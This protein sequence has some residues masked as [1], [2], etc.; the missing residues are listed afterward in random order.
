MQV[1]KPLRETLE[2]MT[3][4]YHRGKVPV[5][6]GSPSRAVPEGK[7]INGEQMTEPT[8]VV[9]PAVNDRF[10]Q[11]LSGPEE[12]R[13]LT[14]TLSHELEHIRESELTSKADFCE[15]Y[16]RYPQFAGGVINI[17]ED[18]YIDFTRTQRFPGLRS[19]QAFVTNQLLADDQLWPPIDSIENSQK[20]M[21]EGFRQVAFAGHAKGIE[22]ADGWLREFLSRVRPQIKRVRRE[23]SQSRRKEIAHAVMKVAKEYLPKADIKMPETCSICKEQSPDIIAPLL[24]PVCEECA[25][26]GHGKHDG[27]EEDTQTKTEIES[28]KEAD[29]SEVVSPDSEGKPLDSRIDES[30]T[31]EGDLRQT[32]TLSDKSSPVSKKDESVGALSKKSDR[33]NDQERTEELTTMD[34]LAR[35]ADTASWWDVP[36]HVDHHTPNEQDVVRYERIRQEKQVDRGLEANLRHQREDTNKSGCSLSEDCAQYSANLRSEEEWYQLRDELRRT[37]RKLTTRDMPIPSKTG[38]DLNMDAVIQRK[39]GDKSQAKLYTR[40]QTVA[41]GNRVVAISADMSGSM[42]GRLVKLAI[43]AIAEATAMVSDTFLATCWRGTSRDSGGY[44][45]QRESTDF[46]LVCGADEPFQWKQLDAFECAGGTPTADGIDLTSQL[47]EDLHARE[48]LMIVI[49]DGKPNSQYSSQELT[50]SPVGDANQVVQNVQSKN[51]NVIGLYVGT[52]GRDTAMA[53][54]FGEDGFV[55]ASMN[56][57]SQ[58]L[59]QIYRR[60]LRV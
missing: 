8:V 50:A 4:V 13:C 7:S 33:K 19:T 35:D 25:P 36:D 22:T 18:Q 52:S 41:R 10:Q 38:T 40:K 39:A 17:L 55:S 57:L 58:E 44:L 30:V 12:L 54:I 60:Q 9:D 16:E 1:S 43:A 59:I 26:T 45:N 37:F 29:T 51:I 49:T 27:I 14:N 56:E 21:L 2:S 34:A 28:D 11:Q 24:G 48:R 6:F 5:K 32:N 42:D 20:A 31:Q 47:M 23:G 15:K 46:G 53:R 3:K